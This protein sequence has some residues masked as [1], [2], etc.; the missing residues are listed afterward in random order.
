MLLLRDGGDGATIQHGVCLLDGDAGAGCDC[1]F[2]D[3]DGVAGGGIEDLGSSVTR[4][5]LCCWWW[6]RWRR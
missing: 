2:E 5:G 6:G 4:E 3:A 1:G